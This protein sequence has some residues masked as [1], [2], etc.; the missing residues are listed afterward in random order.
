MQ[1]RLDDRSEDDLA[2]V[3]ESSGVNDSDAIRLALAESAKRR[4]R[5]HALR[6]EA[7]SLAQD[8]DDVEEA[9]AVRE[10]MDAL[11]TPWPQDG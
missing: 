8:A 1:A 3:R 11:A 6:Q 9:R 4:R 7:E 5:R 2:V 10:E